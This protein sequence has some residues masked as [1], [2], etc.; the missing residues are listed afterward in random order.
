VLGH[1]FAVDDIKISAPFFVNPDQEDGDG[2][3]VGD[4]CDNCPD[5]YNPGQEDGDG[6]GVGDVCD[7]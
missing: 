6:D 3:G 1:T 2:D 4:P 5:V 7:S